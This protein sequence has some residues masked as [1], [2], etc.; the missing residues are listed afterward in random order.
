MISREFAYTKFGVE[1]LL[2]RMKNPNICAFK[3]ISGKKIIGFVEVELKGETGLINGVSV[4]PG[5]RN[6]GVGTS[7]VEHAVEFLKR[8][9]V[10][11]AV[12]LVKKENLT[13][14]KL[15]SSLGFAF[16]GYREKRIEGS[17]IEVWEKALADEE[18]DYLN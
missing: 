16:S 10:E 1:K 12:L 15:Y 5:Q 6:R 4:T 3:K 9:G 14:K 8:R 11:K 17:A 7:L 2:E 18:I 13:A